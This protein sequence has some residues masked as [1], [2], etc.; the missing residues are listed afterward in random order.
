MKLVL[1][2]RHMCFYNIFALRRK[3]FRKIVELNKLKIYS[4]HK[5]TKKYQ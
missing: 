4:W 1:N 5:M 3:S 2:Y